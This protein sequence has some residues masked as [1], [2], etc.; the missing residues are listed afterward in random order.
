MRSI[1]KSYKR[2]S[3][4]SRKNVSRKSR[5][6]IKGGT[7]SNSSYSSN[8]SSSS[9]SYKP[10][11]TS[12]ASKASKIPKPSKELDSI[13]LSR[14]IEQALINNT[15]PL[16]EF[17]SGIVPNKTKQQKTNFRKMIT[18]ALNSNDLINETQ[19]TNK[20]ALELFNNTLMYQMIL[21]KDI[22][23]NI[24][25]FNHTNWNPLSSTENRMSKYFLDGSRYV[26]QTK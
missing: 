18:I 25:K 14:A 19:L 15:E 4:R 17:L 9:S 22:D 5:K 11:K 1:Q 23:L 26:S 12:K 21:Q 2:L 8:S 24:G 6:N 3:L 10:T 16:K 13:I 7:H 20:E